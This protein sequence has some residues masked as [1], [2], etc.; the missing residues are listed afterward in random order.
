MLERIAHPAMP[1]RDVLLDCKLVVR[2]S[3][4]S[5]LEQVPENEDLN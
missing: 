5:H 2:Q 4:G 1:A 3:C